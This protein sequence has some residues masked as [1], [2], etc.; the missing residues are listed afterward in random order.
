MTQDDTER[1]HEGSGESVPVPARRGGTLT[2]WV[3]LGGLLGGAVGQLLGLALPGDFALAGAIGLGVGVALGF[4]VGTRRADA[5][6][7]EIVRRAED[8]GEL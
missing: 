2:L 6:D 5:K 4:A 7:R 1:A 3:I 8:A